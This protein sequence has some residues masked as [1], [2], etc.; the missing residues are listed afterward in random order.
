M[1]Y[2][3]ITFFNAVGT[4]LDPQRADK[5]VNGTLP[6]NGFRYCEPVR[7]A[8]G[9]GWYVFLPL[10]LWVEW[11]GSEYHWSVDSGETWY[12]L[13]DAIQYPDFSADFDLHAPE[14][15]RGYAPPFL[16]RTNDADILQVWTGV[17][18][19]TRPGIATYIKG[20]T[21]MANGHGYSVLEGVIQTEWWF[22]PL[23]TNLRIHQKGAPIVLRRDR[24]LIQLLPFSNALLDDFEAAKPDVRVGLPALREEDWRSYEDTVVRRMRTR[25]RMGDY[26][27]EA[28][29][30]MK[31]AAA[32]G[33]PVAHS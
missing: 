18:A 19:R 21:N 16:S 6:T 1:E 24:P 7:T 32:A 5:S 31:Q 15:V 28:R 29:Q 11:D 10:E 17:F 2:F 12:V 22:G 20:P 8:S 25:T 26:A 9:F 27:V 4:G 13:A 33:C 30:R 23:F 14:A 3:M